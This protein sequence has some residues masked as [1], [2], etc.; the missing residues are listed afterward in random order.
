[1]GNQSTMRTSGEE[2]TGDSASGAV[3]AGTL[4]ALGRLGV[5]ACG[6]ACRTGME[7][8]TPAHGVQRGGSGWYPCL[9]SPTSRQAAGGGCS[10]RTSSRVSELSRCDR[11]KED[12]PGRS[13]C[14]AEAPQH[15]ASKSACKDEATGS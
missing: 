15:T 14:A 6:V 5:A 8:E 4:A 11:R 13:A 3:E 10:R 9:T 2:G 12:A 1:M 7:R